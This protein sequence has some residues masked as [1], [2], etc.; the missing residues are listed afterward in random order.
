MGYGNVKE[1][2]PQ[3]ANAFCGLSFESI[4]VYSVTIILRM[5]ETLSPAVKL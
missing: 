1:E 4:P 3:R 5:A 2:R